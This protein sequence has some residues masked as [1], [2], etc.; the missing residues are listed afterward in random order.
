MSQSEAIASRAR[1]LLVDDEPSEARR[2]QEFLVDRD[3]DVRVAGSGPEALEA[4]SSQAPEVVLLN[5]QASE[6]DG[7][8]VCRRLK[9]D[10]DLEHVPVLLI[11]S[12]GEE[13]EREKG[14]RAGAAD[15]LARPFDLQEGLRRI[16]AHL[17]IARLESRL[18]SALQERDEARCTSERPSADLEAQ[19]RERT[20]QLED[21]NRALREIKTQFEAVYDHHYQLTGLIDR[22]GRLLMGNRTA[23]EFA[24][25]TA[26]DVVGKY[27]WETPWWT[28]SEEEQRKLKEGMARALEGEMV[29]FEST[30]VSA[31]GETK[32]IDFRVGPVF[33]ENGDVIYLVPEGYDITDRLRAEEALRESEE[34]YRTFFENSCDAMLML[35]DNLLLD[36]NAAAVAALGYA[37]AAE[38]LGLHPAELSP[39]FQPDG[40]TSKEKT[41]AM[42]QAARRAGT[43]RFEWEHKRKNGEVFHVEVSLTAMPSEDDTILLAVWRDIAERKQAELSLR[44]QADFDAIIARI[45]ARFSRSSAAVLDECIRTSLEEI[46]RFTGVDSAYVVLVDPDRTTWRVTL[47]WVAPG[48]LDR[49]NEYQDVPMGT[50]PWNEP[51]L[52]AGEIVSVASVEDLPPEAEAERRMFEHDGVG[53]QLDVPLRGRDGKVAGCVGYR[54]YGR[55]VDWDSEDFPR[56]ELVGEAIANVLERQRAEESLQQSEERYRGLVSTM[57]DIIYSVS[58]DGTILFIGPQV[59]RYG[60]T[61]EELVSRSFGELVH[62]EDRE[63]VL[64]EFKHTLATGEQ[65]FSAFR[66]T[67]KDGSVVWFEEIGRV[68][69]DEAGNVVSIAGMLRDISKRKEAEAERERLEDQLRQAQKMEAIGQLAGGVAHDFNNMLQAIQGFTQLATAKAPPDSPV[70]GSLEQVMTASSRAAVLVRQLLAFSRKQVLMLESLDLCDVVEELA[71][72]MHRLIGAHIALVIRAEPGVASIH[73]D[74]GQMEQILMNLCVN[75]RDAMPDGGTLT[76]ETGVEDLSA[77][78]CARHGIETPGRYAYLRVIDT[79]CGMDDATQM[80]IFEPFYTTKG[81]GEGTGLG[82]ST[83]YGIVHQHDGMIDVHSEVGEG[84]RFDIHLPLAPSRPARARDAQAAPPP[85]GTELILLAEDDEV[86]RHL[87]QQLLESAG[88]TVLAAGDG[89]EAIRLFDD[90]R[91]DV[92]LALLDVVMPQSGGRDVLNHIRA[93]GAQTPVLFASGYSP[94]GIHT[95]FVLEEGMELIQK[96]YD[97]GDLLRRVRKLID[98]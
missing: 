24:G 98:G 74:R 55:E 77:E 60:F 57:Q 48:V 72:M 8:E 46:G 96:P 70:R 4:A 36:C 42:V 86:V 69:H 85:T 14:R 71:K 34:K 76:I 75:A 89:A 9:S 58:T 92:G 95:N 61:H 5:V 19:V 62:P 21:A 23:L 88:Y 17:A 83:V 16:E 40:T 38:I 50:L 3:F 2:L 12:T 33:D 31:D 81:E 65:T 53:S 43:H 1:V 87:A 30:H 18:A 49:T 51:R 54:T 27:F 73:A 64:D 6:V 91:E 78:H 93:V 56:L 37:D 15:V 80:R 63:R 28:H 26:E 52:L 47:N 44:R 13:E 90:H 20:E 35:K 82:L 79:G 11:G 7:Y 68:I 45:L 39:E 22:D 66:I 94:S 29:H 41:E 84:T 32:N 25:V 97:Q 59:Q 67:A 10:P